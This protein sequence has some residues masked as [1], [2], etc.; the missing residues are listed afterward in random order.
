MLSWLGFNHRTKLSENNKKLKVSAPSESSLCKSEIFVAQNYQWP[1]KLT[2]NFFTATNE[3]HERARPRKDNIRAAED[4]KPLQARFTAVMLLSDSEVKHEKARRWIISNDDFF[5]LY[6]KQEE[7]Q[8]GGEGLNDQYYLYVSDCCLN[9]V[10]VTM[11]QRSSTYIMT[12]KIGWEV[13]MSGLYME[14]GPP[15]DVADQMSASFPGYLKDR[16]KRS[17]RGIVHTQSSKPFPKRGFRMSMDIDGTGFSLLAWSRPGGHISTGLKFENG[18]VVPV[19][20]NMVIFVNWMLCISLPHLFHL[21]SS[22]QTNSGW[23]P[24]FLNKKSLGDNH[25]IIRK[26][27]GGDVGNRRCTPIWELDSDEEIRALGET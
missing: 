26:I 2:I 3:S 25:H 21:W 17:P 19:E 6:E 18:S 14:D 13:T 20:A 24:S 22:T 8:L 23:R 7:I 27:C 15:T 12:T 11:H 1:M 10:D 4:E 16:K 9:G 5:D